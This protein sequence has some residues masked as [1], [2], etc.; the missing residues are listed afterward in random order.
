MSR[1]LI[2]RTMLAGL[3]ACIGGGAMLTAGDAEA[4]GRRFEQWTY[5]SERPVK[6]YEGF[7]FPGTYCSYR[8]FPVRSCI[9][10]KQ[11]REVCKI[12]SWRMEQSCS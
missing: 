6:G 11:G 9:Y 1:K 4:R 3:A 8:R 12:T 10:D 5:E 2:R 7:L